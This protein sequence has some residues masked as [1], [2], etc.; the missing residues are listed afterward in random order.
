MAIIFFELV[1]FSIYPQSKIIAGKRYIEK[2]SYRNLLEE[3]KVLHI[4]E[5]F[6]ETK[7]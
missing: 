6:S 2:K 7:T 4:V 5:I 3:T 1:T